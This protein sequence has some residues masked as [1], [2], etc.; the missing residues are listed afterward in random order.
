ML[1]YALGTWFLPGPMPM[2]ARKWFTGPH[3]EALNFDVVPDG[4]P[5]ASVRGGD[6]LKDIK[7]PEGVKMGMV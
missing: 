7:M 2:N 1:T 4:G 6:A 3:I 5:G